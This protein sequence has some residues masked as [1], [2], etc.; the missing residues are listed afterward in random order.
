MLQQPLIFTKM[1]FLII[2][3]LLGDLYPSNWNG[4][5][6]LMSAKDLYYLTG[7][8]EGHQHI[9][10]GWLYFEFICIWANGISAPVAYW[11]IWEYLDAIPWA[12]WSVLILSLICT[13]LFFISFTFFLFSFFQNVTYIYKLKNKIKAGIWTQSVLVQ[14]QHWY[15]KTVNISI[16]L[17]D[18]C[19]RIIFRTY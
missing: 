8:K 4:F 19:F 6:A 16:C 14:V 15:S 11:H 13:H 7:R 2:Y 1:W 18:I 3:L 9:P 5:Y 12:A 10:I 17:P